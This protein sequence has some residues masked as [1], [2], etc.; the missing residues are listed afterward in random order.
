M[1]TLFQI[2]N[3]SVLPCWL[4]LVLA[5]RWRWTHVVCSI[6]MPLVL[7][8]LYAWLFSA[9]MGEGGF[10]SLSEVMKLFMQPRAVLAGWVH[11]LAFDLFIGAWLT[12]DAMR[13]ELP[14]WALLPCQLLTFM[15]GP[16][17]LLLYLLLRGTMRKQWEI[18]A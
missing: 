18:G 12:R 15:L 5:P 4:L 7:G 1:E 2:A 9:G 14:R 17:G 10:G 16:L 8:S 13:H 3:M 6:F 11:Y